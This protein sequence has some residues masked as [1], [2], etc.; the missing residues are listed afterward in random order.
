MKELKEGDIFRGKRIREIIKLS[1]GWYLVKTDNTKSPRDFKVRTVWK[2]RPRIRYFTPK[3]AHFAIDFYG[4]LCADKERAIKVFRAIIEV[5]HNKPVE[6]VIKKY[7]DDVASLPGYDLE[8]ILYALK[9]I[10]EQED[11]NFRGRPE[12]KQKQLDEILKK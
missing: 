9:W 8:Y 10:L 1:N 12:S 4:K 5:W 2:L 6:E 3:H 11:I 7:R